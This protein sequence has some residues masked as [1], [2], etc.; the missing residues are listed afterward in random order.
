MNFEE[1]EIIELYNKKVKKS[2]EYFNLSIPIN[3]PIKNGIIV[4]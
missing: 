3:C 2:N 4:G 1:N